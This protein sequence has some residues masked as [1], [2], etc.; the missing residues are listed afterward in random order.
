MGVTPATANIIRYLTENVSEALTEAGN[1]A[2]DTYAQDKTRYN[3]ALLAGLYSLGA[4]APVDALQG[5]GEGTLKNIMDK[6]FMPG[7]SEGFKWLFREYLKNLA[8]EEA[9]ELLQE[10]RQQAV[11]T[12]VKNTFDSGDMSLGNFLNNTVGKNGELWNFPQYFKE[13][14]PSTAKSTLITSLLMA[15]FE[16]GG[17]DI[18]YNI[19]PDTDTQSIS[20]IDEL[21][22]QRDTLQEELNKAKASQADNSTTQ[23]EQPDIQGMQSRLD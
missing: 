1:A 9:N 2:S 20:R 14:G 10:P 23:G 18:G 17:G 3:D 11:E 13:V 15:P 6:H 16:L 4:N 19:T 8:K 5:L 22:K 12:A 21:K 7:A